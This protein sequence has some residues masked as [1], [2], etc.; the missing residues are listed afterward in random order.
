MLNGPGAPQISGISTTRPGARPMHLHLNRITTARNAPAGSR[1]PRPH[2]ANAPNSGST[3]C[4]RLSLAS[5][6]W[7]DAFD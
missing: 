7:M 5:S 2:R 6:L 3:S 1:S 4:P